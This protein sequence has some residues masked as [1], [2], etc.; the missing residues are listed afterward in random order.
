LSAESAA[1]IIAE[2][3][4]N[5]GASEEGLNAARDHAFSFSSAADRAKKYLEILEFYS[6]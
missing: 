4:N 3:F 5:G 1:T 6:K 2:F